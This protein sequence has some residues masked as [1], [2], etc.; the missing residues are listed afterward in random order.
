MF[1]EILHQLKRMTEMQV[2]LNNAEA[3]MVTLAMNQIQNMTHVGFWKARILY[4][5][6]YNHDHAA[7][8]AGID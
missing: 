2:A 6:P 5:L 7:G 3:D 1:A 4:K 8:W